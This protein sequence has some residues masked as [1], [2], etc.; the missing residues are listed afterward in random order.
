MKEN[1]HSQYNNYN[2][3]FPYWEYVS[4][5][6]W[7]HSCDRILWYVPFW[8]GMHEDSQWLF[9]AHWWL[10]SHTCMIESMSSHVVSGGLCSVQWTTW[11]LWHVIILVTRHLFWNIRCIGQS[12]R[13]AYIYATRQNHWH[14]LLGTVSPC[15]SGSCSLCGPISD[16]CQSSQYSIEWWTR[17]VCSVICDMMKT[18]DTWS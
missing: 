18:T 2:T 15:H 11:V 14:A 7:S 16:P 5:S 3:W 10:F 1:Q 4:W 8:Q 12:S 6:S 17:G 9:G 13:G